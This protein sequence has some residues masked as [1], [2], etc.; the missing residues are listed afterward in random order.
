MIGVIG[1]DL[2]LLAVTEAVWT[3][4]YYIGSFLLTMLYIFI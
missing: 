3:V 2:L 1:I 4:I